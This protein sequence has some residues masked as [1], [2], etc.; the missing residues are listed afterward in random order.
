MLGTINVTANAADNVGVAGVQFRLDGANLGSEDTTA[1]Y[2]VPWDTRTAANGDAHADGDRARR[3]RQQHDRHVG[4]GQRRQPAR[5]HQRPRRRVRLRG[6]SGTAVTDT[7]SQANAGTISGATRT[8]AGRFG[9]ALSFNG[10]N[11]WVTV[12]DAN[13][14][15]LTTAMTLEAW[16]NPTATGNWRTVL[17]KEGTGG[18]VLRDV[19]QQLDEPPERARA[20]RLERARHA[21][22]GAAAAQ[23]VDAPGRDLRRREPAALRQRHAGRRRGPPPARSLAGSGPLRI[24]GNAFAWGEFFD[25]LIDEVRVYNRALTAARSRST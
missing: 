6:G 14:L 25:G 10:A 2:S 11:D 13:S 16:V 8:A 24:G 9:G 18:A 1:P 7:S 23:H 3:R 12:P 4:R 19:R 5:R 17:I 22:H 21:R 20:H 15:D